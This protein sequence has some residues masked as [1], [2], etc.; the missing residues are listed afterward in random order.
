[1]NIFNPQCTETARCEGAREHCDTWNE[2]E[3]QDPECECKKIHKCSKCG[4]Q[5]G[6]KKTAFKRSCARRDEKQK[7]R[8]AMELEVDSARRRETK[9]NLEDMCRGQPWG[10]DHRPPRNRR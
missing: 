3:G 6:L 7:V 1:M 5:T 8:R 4:R 2:E 9:A 10:Q